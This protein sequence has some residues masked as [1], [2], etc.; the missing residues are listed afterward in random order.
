MALHHLLRM[1]L[2]RGRCPTLD[3]LLASGFADGQGDSQANGPWRT[4]ADNN[5]FPT[6]TSELV[7]TPMDRCGREPRGIENRLRG[8]A[9]AS[10][11]GSIPIHPR[12]SCPPSQ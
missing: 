6:L 2:A 8:A 12:Q 10:W 4:V 9:E 11:V 7:W 5:G 3:L 1:P